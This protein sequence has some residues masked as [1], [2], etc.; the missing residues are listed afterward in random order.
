MKTIQQR[1]AILAALSSIGLLVSIL[2]F[3]KSTLTFQLYLNSFVVFVFPL[4][5]LLL[6]LSIGQYKKYIY[7]KL[8][9]ENKIINFQAAKIEQKS[10]KTSI[11]TI[12]IWDMEI[13]ISC[14]GILFGSKVIKFNSEGISL[15]EVEIGHDFVSIV[16]AKGEIKKTIK[17]IHGLLGKSDIEK[18]V[19]R[20][21]YETGIIP[22]VID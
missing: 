5:I 17:L 9:I 13:F 4:S 12:S 10:E 18:I 20:F 8:I 11:D 2:L 22:V 21:H 7:A 3:V 6:V 14:F 19:N 15:E 1:L 16:Y